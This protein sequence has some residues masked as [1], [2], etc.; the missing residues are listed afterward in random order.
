M[1][2]F[3]FE[4]ID[5]LYELI[6]DIHD[7]SGEELQLT[8]VLH[9]LFGP[10]VAM[11]A[12]AALPIAL[13]PTAQSAASINPNPKTVGASIPNVM[14]TAARLMLTHSTKGCM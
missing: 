5:E 10:Q 3:P 11:Y 2:I 6:A 9:P 4:P 1:Y 7:T 13:P 12:T 14:F 8:I